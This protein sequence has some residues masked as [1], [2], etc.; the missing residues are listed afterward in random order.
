[1]IILAKLLMR[2]MGRKSV[3][4]DASFALGIKTT[5]AS[6][7]KCSRCVLIQSLLFMKECPAKTTAVTACQSLVR[8]VSGC[9]LML[10]AQHKNIFHISLLLKWRYYILS[11][12][13]V[14][15]KAERPST[16]L[17]KWRYDTY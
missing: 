3:M 5:F 17:E 9:Q 8:L 16:L 7:I 2:L 13:I 6:L 11:A 14:S 15:E 12:L 4:L 10:N 1:V